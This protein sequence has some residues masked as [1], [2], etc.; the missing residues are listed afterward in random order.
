MS[1][2]PFCKRL[3]IQGVTG[4]IGRSV[5]SIVRAHR[6]RFEIVGVSAG[7]NLSGLLEIA[8]E[9]D[10]NSIALEN[11]SKRDSLMEA[12][13][14][15]RVEKTY[16]GPDAIAEQSAQ[17][18]YD[19]LVNA[20]MGG[21]GLEPTA[22]ALERGLSVALANKE[23]MVAAGP[24]MSAIAKRTGARILPI[25]SEHSAIFQC[26]SGEDRGAIRRIWL[27]TS[28]G[29]FWGRP[30]VSLENVTVEDALAHPTWNMGAKITVDS[31]TL[32]NKGLEVIEA[33]RLFGVNAAQIEVVAHRQS[34]VH[35]LV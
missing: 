2:M 33:E 29:P 23:T 15:L 30:S 10:V 20:V 28:G 17:S 3:L 8:R 6:D 26:L 25:D 7:S 22:T 32:F 1:D 21:A 14:R 35:S 4:S 16:V 12:S 34:I 27:T 11:D 18:D 13:A 24:I 31:A 9:F 19:L 5:L